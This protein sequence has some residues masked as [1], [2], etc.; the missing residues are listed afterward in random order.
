M[1]SWSVLCSYTALQSVKILL[2]CIL[3]PAN[4]SVVR[5]DQIPARLSMSV[6]PLVVT[7][8]GDMALIE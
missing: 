7:R 6:L 3:L 2:A 8:C 5:Y 1:N 4:S